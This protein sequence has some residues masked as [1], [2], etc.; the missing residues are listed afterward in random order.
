MGAVT[1]AGNGQANH[2]LD[3]KRKKRNERQRLEKALSEALEETFPP[4]DAVVA[5]KP[6]RTPPLWKVEVGSAFPGVSLA[7]GPNQLG[8]AFGVSP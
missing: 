5:T 7:G 8:R 4:S 6:A 3:I 1:G 2:T